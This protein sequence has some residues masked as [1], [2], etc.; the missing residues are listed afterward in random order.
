MQVKLC[1]PAA[2][3]GNIRGIRGIGAPRQRTTESITIGTPVPGQ[4][5]R[6]SPRRDCVGYGRRVHSGVVDRGQLAGTLAE[7]CRKFAVPRLD[8]DQE[9][10]TALAET[11]L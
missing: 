2:C 4:R 1:R 10:D 11:L 7:A 6:L 9:S 8:L 3:G 5:E